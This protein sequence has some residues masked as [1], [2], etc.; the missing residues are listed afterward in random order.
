VN[1]IKVNGKAIPLH[2]TGT[3]ASVL[4]ELGITPKHMAVEHNGS[5]VPL[6]ALAGTEVRSGD[7]IEIIQFVGGG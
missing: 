7:I 4:A 6:E 2:D 3:I 5:I 1:T